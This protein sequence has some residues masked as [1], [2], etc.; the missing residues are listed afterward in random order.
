VLRISAILLSVVLGNFFAAKPAG[1]GGKNQ[2]P[3]FI[4]AAYR[5]KKKRKWLITDNVTSATGLGDKNYERGNVE[6]RKEG[7]RHMR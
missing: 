4:R 3:E 2:C 6:G 5:H 1:Q 7:S